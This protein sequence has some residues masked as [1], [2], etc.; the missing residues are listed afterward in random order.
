MGLRTHSA[1]MTYEAYETLENPIWH[2]FTEEE[3]KMGN[4]P[5]IEKIDKT[6]KPNKKGKY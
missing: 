2:V 3:M 6:K 4:V 1:S 5:K